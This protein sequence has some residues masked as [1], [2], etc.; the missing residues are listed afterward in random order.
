MRIMA[1]TTQE[2]I[3]SIIES[4]DQVISDLANAGK[5]TDEVAQAITTAKTQ[6]IMAVM[7]AKS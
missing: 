6:S 2:K 3:Q 5:L 7:E 4:F 1:K